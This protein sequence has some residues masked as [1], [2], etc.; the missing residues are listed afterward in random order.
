MK[1]L[2][3]LPALL[4][5]VLLPTLSHAQ[6]AAES[7]AQVKKLSEQGNH[8]EAADLGKAALAKPDDQSEVTR[9][10]LWKT[11]DALGSLNAA[12]EQEEVIE[13]TVRLH[14]RE[15]AVLRGA[16]KYY[17]TLP[18]SAPFEMESS[19]AENQTI[20]RIAKPQS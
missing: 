3:W 19:S 11:L 1:N 4:L 10:L 14:P 7:L 8:R 16:G 6:T 20:G 12:Q 5:A 15:Y 2:P 13:A 17:L 18:I 9:E